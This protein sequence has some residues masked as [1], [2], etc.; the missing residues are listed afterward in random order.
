[1]SGDLTG[2]LRHA[3]AVEPATLDQLFRLV[4]GDLRKIA[5][6][7]K[8]RFQNTLDAGVGEVVGPRTRAAG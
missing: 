2:L 7:R 1:M 3:N 5:H 8:W 4:K 6:N